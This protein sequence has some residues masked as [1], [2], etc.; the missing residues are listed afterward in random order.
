MS[1]ARTLAALTVGAV[2]L[3]ATPTANAAEQ[4]TLACTTV[5]AVS[6]AIQH[7][8]LYDGTGPGGSCITF[9]D[10][11]SC[12]AGYTDIEG[13]YNLRGWGWDNRASSVVTRNSCD[14]RLYDA[15]DCPSTGAKSGWIDY[16]ENLGTW[17]N[18]ASC[19]I[20]S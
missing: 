9:Y 20:V 12:T 1:I 18:K 5:G 4:G 11:G 8:T 14:V 17:S 19:L 7:F 10:Y 15:V 3:I 16:S 13:L 2:A 6:G